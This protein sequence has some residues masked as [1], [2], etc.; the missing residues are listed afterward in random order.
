MNVKQLSHAG[1]VN[2]ETRSVEVYIQPLVFI[3]VAASFTAKISSFET[4]T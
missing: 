4:A 2:S 3:G 1:E